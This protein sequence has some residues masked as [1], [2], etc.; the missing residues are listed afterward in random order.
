[1]IF[2]KNDDNPEIQGY[3]GYYG[4]THW[5]LTAFT[6]EE[7]SYIEE[8]YSPMYSSGSELTTGDIQF[9]NQ[10]VTMFLSTLSGWFKKQ[11]DYEIFI[12]IRNQLE[13][14]R[15][16][17]PDIGPGTYK[18]AHYTTY[19]EEVKSLKRT[20]LFDRAETLLLHLIDAV[21][22]E[23]KKYNEDPA[24]WY[25]EQ[26]AIIYRK[27]KKYQEEISILSRFH[28]SCIKPYHKNTYNKRIEKATLLLQ[29]S[30]SD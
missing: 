13:K 5:W 7:R 10:H 14:S 18:G 17:D 3:I 24:P 9:M 30:L 16:T 19:V 23:S 6:E 11:D 29:K 25:Y 22:E 12:K 26:L 28:D 1:M 2:M 20:Y 27:E 15:K 21:E 4:L 8:K